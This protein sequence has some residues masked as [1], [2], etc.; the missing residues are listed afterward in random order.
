MKILALADTHAHQRSFSRLPEAD[1]FLHAGDFTRYGNGAEEFAVW[2]HRL[3]YKLKLLTL[4]NHERKDSVIK[5]DLE[6]WRSLFGPMLLLD[7]GVRATVGRRDLV[8]F[9]MP[10]ATQTVEIPAGVDIVLSHEPPYG[11]LDRTHGGSNAGSEQVAALVERA[12]PPAHVFGHVHA[13]GGASRAIDATTYINAATRAVLFEL[14][15]G[16]VNV[17]ESIK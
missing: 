9:G 7:R 2:F 8:V 1:V 6:H 4:G 14:Q 15:N 12:R 11:V 10:H 16:H 13:Q 17:L 5:Y 3:P